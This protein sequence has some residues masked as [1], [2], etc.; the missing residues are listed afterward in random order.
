VIQVQR[1]FEN[2]FDDAKISSEELRNFAEDHIGK[3]K[4]AGASHAA[5]VTA[6]EAAFGPFDAALSERA[7]Q[8]GSLGGNTVTKNEVVQLFRTKIRQ[9]RGRVVDAF[10]EESAEYREIF[11]QG[12]TYYTRA[13]M[14]TLKQRLDYVVE[15]FTKYQAEL[16]AALVAEFEGLRTQFVNARDEQ[17]GDKGSVSQARGA[18]KT[19][20]TALELQLTDNLLAL[21][22]EFKGRPEKAA[23]FFTQSLLEDPT[24]SEEP[25]EPPKP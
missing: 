14:E 7:G 2:A 10:G 5:M 13:T 12:L 15:K 19:T 25:E 18:V 9:R 6:T 23:E 4:A 21:A 8:I 3:L 16:G 24:Q 1:Y 22:K 20:R 11:P 17:V